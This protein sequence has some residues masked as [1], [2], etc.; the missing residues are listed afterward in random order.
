MRTVPKDLH[1]HQVSFQCHSKYSKHHHQ[2]KP[3][4][5]LNSS[6]VWYRYLGHK[7]KEI[8]LAPFFFPLKELAG[9]SQTVAFLLHGCT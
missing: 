3:N 1:A 5:T 6:K 2:L 9:W 8:V 4:K 7:A